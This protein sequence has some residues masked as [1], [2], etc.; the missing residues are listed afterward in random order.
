MSDEKATLVGGKP[1][2]ADHR[3]IDPATGMQKEYVVLSAEERAKG[4]VRPYREKYIHV[5][6]GGHE[7]DP[8]DPSKSG[9]KGKGCGAETR[10][11]REI[12]ETYAR[13][14]KFYNGTFCV[15]CKTHLPLAEFVWSDTDE[16]VGS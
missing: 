3:E 11:H 2:S 4:F 13:D 16:R 14:P 12:A 1:I 7:V 9:L 6:V 15:G 8:N 10:M 5:G